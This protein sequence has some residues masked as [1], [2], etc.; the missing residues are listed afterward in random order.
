MKKYIALVLCL[1]LLPWAYADSEKTVNFPF[2]ITG[3]ESLEECAEILSSTF[4][5]GEFNH[6]DEKYSMYVIN[7]DHELYGMKATRVATIAHKDTGK[8]SFVEVSLRD[9]A[10]TNGIMNLLEIVLFAFDNY[11]NM[12]NSQP[13]KNNID[14]NG[15]KVYYAAAEE[16]HQIEDAIMSKQNFEYTASWMS[17]FDDYTMLFVINVKGN[18][19]DSYYTTL[20]WNRSWSDS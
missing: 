15:N 12:F 8:I 17:T 5:E 3:E 1:L 16:M 20:D 11:G 9:N 2:G 13:I 14:L 7:C 18:G 10:K 6:S 4:G 19:T